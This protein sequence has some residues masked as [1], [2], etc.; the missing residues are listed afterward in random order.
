MM[1]VEASPSEV[2]ELGVDG[3]LR[4][5][6]TLRFACID[7]ICPLQ[8]SDRRPTITS[9]GALR[10]SDLAHDRKSRT[11]G[12]REASLARARSDPR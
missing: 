12:G 5:G 9:M 11:W 8:C 10:W 6:R 2:R 4:P 3:I 7:V 1:V